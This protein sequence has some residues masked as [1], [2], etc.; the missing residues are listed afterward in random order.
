MSEI[1]FREN[2]AGDALYRWELPFMT[3]SLSSEEFVKRK[4]CPVTDQN[5]WYSPLPAGAI[6][7]SSSDNIVHGEG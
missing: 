4:G 2:E 3:V 5:V 7:G 6:G 1:S